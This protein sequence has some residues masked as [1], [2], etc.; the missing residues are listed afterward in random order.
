MRQID[1]WSLKI[2]EAALDEIFPS[3]R[4]KIIIKNQFLF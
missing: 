3:Q 4:N 2:N 1:R